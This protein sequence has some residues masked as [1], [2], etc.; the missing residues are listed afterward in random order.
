[1]DALLPGSGDPA[2]LKFH[3]RFKDITIGTPIRVGLI[4]AAV[5]GVDSLTNFNCVA[6]IQ[7]FFGSSAVLEIQYLPEDFSLLPLEGAEATT[8]ENQIEASLVA[9]TLS[10]S[11]NANDLQLDIKYRVD[12]PMRTSYPQLWLAIQRDGGVTGADVEEM[13]ESFIVYFPSDLKSRLIAG[14]QNYLTL[15]DYKTHGYSNLG[16]GDLRLKA[17]VFKWTSGDNNLYWNFAIDDNANGKDIIPSVAPSSAGVTTFQS[18]QFVESKIPLG[19]PFL[20]ES[21]MKRPAKSGV[22][23]NSRYPN[24]PNTGLITECYYQRDLATG[25]WK[26]GITNLST[27]EFIP[28][29]NF[30]GGVQMGSEELRIRRLFRG[31]YS[32]GVA[33]FN[34]KLSDWRVYDK[35]PAYSKLRSI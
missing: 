15:L 8:I 13:Y 35:I 21:Y 10:S 29:G 3:T 34:I 11:P 20:F 17:E 18:Q 5:T 9:S 28:L 27:Q 19:T 14:G 12:S 7:G 30:V 22:R 24:V 32:T 31:V 2:K 33:P 6:D 4:R 1:M 23:S 16:Y 26:C 25:R